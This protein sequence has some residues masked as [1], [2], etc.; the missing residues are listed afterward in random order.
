M[1]DQCSAV[2]SKSDEQR[3][4]ITKLLCNLF[5]KCHPIHILQYS[6]SRYCFR[7][8][9]DHSIQ[10]HWYAMAFLLAACCKHHHYAVLYT[11]ARAVA[12]SHHIAN[13]STTPS[14]TPALCCILLL[15]HLP[16]H[17]LVLQNSCLYMTSPTFSFP[18][19]PIHIS[20]STNSSN[21]QTG[22]GTF[23]P[24]SRTPRSLR[25]NS[26]LSLDELPCFTSFILIHFAPPPILWSTDFH[27]ISC[28]LSSLDSAAALHFALQC[29]S[30]SLS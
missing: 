5:L 27:F 18:P 29:H 26:V 8:L 16:V 4:C 21:P 9:Q 6:P 20:P 2:T 1:Q 17:Y 13:T 30:T 11:H 28:M 22:I 7:T 19:T 15:F 14:T 25:R 12:R 23:P 3:S 10:Y 24:S